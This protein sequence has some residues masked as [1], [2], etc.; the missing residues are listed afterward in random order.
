[1][2]QSSPQTLN[3]STTIIDILL[4][5]SL[6]DADDGPSAH[7]APILCGDHLGYYRE[8]FNSVLA[9]CLLPTNYR[10]LSSAIR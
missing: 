7:W 2:S 4:I 9:R 1:M 8:Y 10:E 3:E 6:F 5:H